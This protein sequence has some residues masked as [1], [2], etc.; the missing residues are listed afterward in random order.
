[1]WHSKKR[2]ADRFFYQHWQQ[3]KLRII[4]KLKPHCMILKI[5]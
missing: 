3:P 2:N 5:R 4:C 1:M